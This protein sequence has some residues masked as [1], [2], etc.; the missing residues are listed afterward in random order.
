MPKKKSSA[1]KLA[2]LYDALEIPQKGKVPCFGHMLYGNACTIDPK[3]RKDKIESILSGIIDVTTD[4]STV[5]PAKAQKLIQKLLKDLAS[6]LVCTSMDHEHLVFYGHNAY[7]KHEYIAF[8]L[9]RR[10]KNWDRDADRETLESKA[11]SSDDEHNYVEDSDE[12]YDD[13]FWEDEYSDKDDEDE[14][15]Y[16]GDGNEEEYEKDSEGGDEEVTK[17][18]AKK[19]TKSK[20]Q[21]PKPH[22]E[23]TM[24]DKAACITPTKQR[25]RPRRNSRPSTPRTRQV[26]N[27]FDSLSVIDDALPSSPE[28]VISPG[29]SEVFS[30]FSTASTPMTIPDSEIRPR[31]SRYS[32]SEDESPTRRRST[33]DDEL[34]DGARR[35]RRSA[36]KDTASDQSQICEYYD[37]IT[38][39]GGKLSRKGNK[40]PDQSS[41]LDDQD[42]D[43][44]QHT[45]VGEELEEQPKS[46]KKKP[47]YSVKAGN[48]TFDP[49]RKVRNPLG[50]LRERLEKPLEEKSLSA[51]WIYCFAEKT[52]PGYLKIGYKEYKDKNPN[53]VLSRE[54][55]NDTA[56]VMKR[57]RVW[58]RECQHDIDYKFIF[59][60][61]Y[62]V[63]TIEGLIHRTLYKSRRYA[64]CPNPAC[65]KGHIEW[66]EISEMKARRAVEVWQQFSEL[67]PYSG[68]GQ[69]RPFWHNRTR[70]DLKSYSDL[71]VKEWVYERWVKVIVPAA[72]EREK[73]ISELQEKGAR[74]AEKRKEAQERKKELEDEIQRLDQKEK[75]IQQELAELQIQ[76]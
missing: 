48:M 30:P 43:S 64:S 40:Q 53:A 34:L 18:S 69:L 44:Q 10:L 70:D 28:S 25:G 7:G 51:G 17:V 33:K 2:S 57:L 26:V 20:H 39:T 66:F 42:S 31:R 59:Y 16:D 49:A 1:T 13:Q 37:K 9:G 12:N 61:P 35:S 72:V 73:Q 58:V 62:A 24:I 36:D 21:R 11:T 55:Q 38:T 50:S 76:H 5:N 29:V 46:K 23:T 47:S 6:R 65:T 60:M 41:Q 75:K 71:T 67:Q 15:G 27:P 32:R 74:L 52:A 54:E 63:R 14:D 45:E 4:R 3:Q 56:Q 19:S 68:N 22:R 8:M